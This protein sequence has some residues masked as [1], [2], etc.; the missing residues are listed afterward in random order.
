[1]VVPGCRAEMLQGGVEQVEILPRANLKLMTARLDNSGPPFPQNCICFKPGS[2]AVEQEG[3]R[4]RLVERDAGVNTWILDFGARGEEAGVAAKTIQH[5]NFNQLCTVGKSA[6]G[7]GP[8]MQYFTVDGSSTAAHREGEDAIS[9]DPNLVAARF[10]QGR[11]KVVEGAD[12]WMLDFNE[13]EAD[14]RRAVEI[15][16]YYNFTRVCYVG[17]PGAPMMYFTR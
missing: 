9:F 8:E 15:I 10:V 14:A 1:M 17:R 11:W 7:R 12:H 16:K 2:I 4:Y 13:R 3:G 5:Y 6:D